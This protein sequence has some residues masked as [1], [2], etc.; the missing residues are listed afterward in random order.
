MS[1]NEGDMTAMMQE[2]RDTLAKA[3]QDNSSTE[4][5]AMKKQLA[6]LQSEIQT[7]RAKESVSDLESAAHTLVGDRKIDTQLAMGYIRQEA[8][9]DPSFAELWENRVNDPGA[10]KKRLDSMAERFAKGLGEESKGDDS[11]TEAREAVAAAAKASAKTDL[12]SGEEKDV[13][14]LRGIELDR[15]FKR[16]INEYLGAKP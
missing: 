7:L 5:A 14:Q 2:M 1:T 6:A 15:E 12:S 10:L 8:A 9:S 16:Q 11:I 13:S 4:L 3:K